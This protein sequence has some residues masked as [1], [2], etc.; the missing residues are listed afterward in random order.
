MPCSLKWLHGHRPSIEKAAQAKRDMVARGEMPP[1][2]RATGPFKFADPALR[3]AMHH[4]KTGGHVA[5]LSPEQQELYRQYNREQARRFKGRHRKI[6]AGLCRVDGCDRKRSAKGLCA[7]HY[8][9][10]WRGRPLSGPI[11]EKAATY[12]SAGCSWPGCERTIV[13]KGFCALHYRR[14]RT[15]MEMSAPLQSRVP[16]GTWQQ[17]ACAIDGCDR[18]VYARAL[19]TRHYEKAFRPPRKR[20]PHLST[21]PCSIC[22]KPEQAAR[23]MCWRHYQQWRRNRK[24]EEQ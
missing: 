16:S 10:A 20:N 5:D 17:A 19:C 3:A 8:G 23:G 2:P 18:P 13:A 12:E 11:R 15:G 9:R 1:P 4:V 21:R 24:K 22:G 7:A 14:N 6:A